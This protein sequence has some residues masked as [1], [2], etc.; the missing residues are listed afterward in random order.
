[1]QDEE[2]YKPPNATLGNSELDIH[3]LYSPGQIGVAAFIGGPI[4]GSWLLA[5]NF[6]SL[7][8]RDAKTK[9]VIA[10]IVLTACVIALSLYLPDDFPA[11]VFPF[12][13]TVVFFQLAG[14]LQGYDVRQFI[15]DGGKRFSHWRVL[16]ISVVS[17]VIF[18][19]VVVALV[20]LVPAAFEG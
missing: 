14:K 15:D 4:A 5:S 6:A 17:I 9:T 10:G 2:L 13:Y 11:L 7:G 3:G 12:V 8:K 19:L 16:G 18:M 1:M 20:L